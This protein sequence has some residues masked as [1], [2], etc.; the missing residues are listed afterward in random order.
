V[1][2]KGLDGL[3][4]PADGRAIGR[5]VA[6]DVDVLRADLPQLLV[7][8]AHGRHRAP[9]TLHLLGGEAAGV[10]AKYHLLGGETAVGVG[11]AQLA[12]RVAHHVVGLDAHRPEE[13]H[14]A[15]LQLPGLNF[16]GLQSSLCFFSSS[17]FLFTRGLA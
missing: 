16:D 10:G 11:A 15:Y 12:H 3:D 7:A 4:G 6:R 9:D 8:D 1:S 13:V 14:E 5:V 2:D 17:F